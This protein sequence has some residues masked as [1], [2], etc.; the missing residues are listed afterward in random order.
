MIAP[1]NLSGE[2]SSVQ[3]DENWRS[4]LAKLD[5]EEL[6]KRCF[7]PVDAPRMIGPGSRPEQWKLPKRIGQS[8]YSR[9]GEILET[10]LPTGFQWSPPIEQPY[11]QRYIA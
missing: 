8:V 9:N 1:K 3:F 4:N 7:W 6:C 10:T 5:I 2:K 11:E